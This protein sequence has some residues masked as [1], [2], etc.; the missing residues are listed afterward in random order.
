MMDV[1]GLWNEETDALPEGM[2]NGILING[3]PYE[4]KDIC[5][6]V[7]PI[8][9]EV[10]GVYESEFYAG[11]AALTVNAFGSGKAYYIAARTER[12][13]LRDFYGG[14]IEALEIDRALDT[15]PPK[16]VTAH[17]RYTEEKKIVFVENYTDKEK[18]VE[19]GAEQELYGSRQRGK[20]LKLEPFG[21]AVLSVLTKIQ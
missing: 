18:T 4:A 2:T 16:G 9:A 10:L 17:A 20:S 3:E 7:H 5:A 11:R 19:L 6:L 21:R 14:Q 15:V 8:T 12:D 1:F 13:F